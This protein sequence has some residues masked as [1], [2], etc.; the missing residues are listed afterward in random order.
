MKSVASQWHV[1]AGS[2][3]ELLQTAVLV[4][5][6]AAASCGS[7]PKTHYYTLRV[8]SPPASHDPRSAAVLGLER[9]GAPE[10]L[11]DDRIVFYESPTQLNFYQYQRWSSDPATMIRDAIAHRLKQSGAFGEVLLLP[12]R[13]PADYLLR[14]RLE[15]FEEVDFD[16]GV[17][18]RVALELTLLRVRDRKVLWSGRR[19][20]LGAV[21]GKDITAVVEALNGASEKVIN[22][23][24]PS[25]VTAV[26][27]DLQ[28]GVRA[29]P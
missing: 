27:Q 24:L 23:L 29:S 13:D 6:A 26:E 18:G 4:A 19:Q 22:E 21:E 16:G 11:R 17:K 8:P 20:G 15:N 28:Q 12:A 10:V 14:G 3:R 5:V 1:W 25:V 9:L 7:V 2:R